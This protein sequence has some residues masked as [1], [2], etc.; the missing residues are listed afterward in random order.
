[1]KMFAFVTALLLGAGAATAQQVE[2]G[3]GSVAETVIRLKP[4]EYVWSPQIAP[5]GPMLLIVNLTSQRAVLYRNGVPV[6]ATTVSTGRPG[7]STP[8]GV[9]TI[10]QK[11]VEHYS[12]T[13]DNA[14]MP[15]MQRLTWRGIALHAGQLPGYPA[16]HGCIR[17]PAG[18]ARLL[19]GVTRL[20]MTVVIAE[21]EAIPRI[22]PTPSLTSA[23]EGSAVPDDTVIDWTPE[24][25][26]S[27]PVSI[28]VSA[29]DRRAFVLRNG[30]LIGSGPVQ[31]EGPVNGTWAYALQRMDAAGQHWTR[32]QLSSARGAAEKVPVEEWQ[33]FRAPEEFRRK[34]ASIIE[35]GATIVVTADSVKPGAALTVLDSEEPRPGPATDPRR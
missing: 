13:Y 11:H 2:L 10:L 12:T 23:G 22:A 9:F 35:P 30:V 29:S 27:G 31:V 16:S 7:Y 8:T 21:S 3:S 32:V 33:R 24:K 17:L 5:A 26:P 34:V 15:Y 6:A 20:G 28:V 18:F 4:G 1:M 19:Y 14:P 25:A